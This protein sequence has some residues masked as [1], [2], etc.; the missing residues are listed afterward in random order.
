MQIDLAIIWRLIKMPRQNISDQSEIADMI[1]H[2]SI[3]NSHALQSYICQQ[4]K[5]NSLYT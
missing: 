2:S 3:N 5:Y 1:Q 4:C